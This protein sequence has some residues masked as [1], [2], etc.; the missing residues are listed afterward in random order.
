MAMM[1]DNHFETEPWIWMRIVPI[2]SF[3]NTDIVETHSQGSNRA[4]ISSERTRFSFWL[5]FSVFTKPLECLFHID[6]LIVIKS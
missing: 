2:K 6:G 1:F 4:F 5:D 3:T